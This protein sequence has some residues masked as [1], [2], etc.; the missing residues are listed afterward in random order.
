[1]DR[2]IRVSIDALGR[3]KI[4]AE[5]F[6]GGTCTDATKSIEVALAGGGGSVER[7]L[8]PEWYESGETAQQEQEQQW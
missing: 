8:K 7:V 5:G 3:P 6:H 1:M 2:K 4:E